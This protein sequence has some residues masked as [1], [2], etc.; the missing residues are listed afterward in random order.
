MGVQIPDEK[1]QFWGEKGRQTVKYTGT[2]CGEP[3]NGWTDR[4]A[5]SVL[6]LDGPKETWACTLTPSEMNRPCAAAM[7]P[8][9]QITL[10]TCY[11]HYIFV[12]WFLL[13]LSSFVF[14]QFSAVADWICLPYF[15]TWCGLSANLECRSEM[16]CMRLA[17]ST[18]GKKLPKKFATWA[19]SH[20]FVGLDLRNCKACIDNRKHVKQQYLLHM[21]P[22]YGELR[23][24]SGWD[25]FTSLGHPRKFQLSSWLCYC[26][27]VAQWRST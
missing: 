6:N 14:P 21:T 7:R 11:G 10:T 15:Y 20:N 18:E 8:F 12:M 1:G 19:P 9:C 25:R 27:D 26:S 16:C 4:D 24:I 17:E 23:P 13:L 3:C 22:R 2:L 5:L